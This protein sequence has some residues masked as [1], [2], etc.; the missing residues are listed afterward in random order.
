M[1]AKEQNNALLFT[2]IQ[3]TSPGVTNLVKINDFEFIGASVKNKGGL[4]KYNIVKSMD[5]VYKI[6]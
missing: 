4:Y 6:S 1:A 2:K 3:S 5:I